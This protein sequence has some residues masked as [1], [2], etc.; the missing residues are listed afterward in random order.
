MVLLWC[1]LEGDG[2]QETTQEVKWIITL[3]M[4]FFFL[5]WVGVFAGGFAKSRA[6]LWCF[7]GEVVVDCVVNVVSWRILLWCGKIGQLFQLYFLF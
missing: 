6:F 1:G 4:E 5:W 3:F 7:C 2:E